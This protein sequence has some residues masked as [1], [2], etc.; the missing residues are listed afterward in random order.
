MPCRMPANPARAGT[1]SPG[2]IPYIPKNNIVPPTTSPTAMFI[3]FAV[4]KSFL[5][6]ASRGSV[7]CPSWTI[8]FASKM[9]RGIA[10]AEKRP[11]KTICGPD[12]GIMPISTASKRT[13]A[14]LSLMISS[15]LKYASPAWTANN[16]PNVHR[17]TGIIC[18]L[19]I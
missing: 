2:Q 17:K 18:L 19:I 7:E 9:E 6:W 12:S 4:I 1:I 16:A 15:A 10:P 14:M 11:M 13:R 5:L 3:S 8:E